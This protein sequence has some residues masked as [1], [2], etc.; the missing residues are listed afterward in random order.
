[1]LS[2]E[3][4]E[5]LSNGGEIQIRSILVQGLLTMDHSLIPPNLEK[6]K[7]GIS[8]FQ[9]I[10]KE[11][12]IN[13]VHLAI[14][15]INYLLPRARIIIGIDNTKQIKD[16]LSINKSKLRDSDIKAILKVCRSYSGDH[17]D[18]RKW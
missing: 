2:E 17:W 9:N 16:L 6:T 5:F 14:L 11:L 3:I 10:A 18:P 7:K 13:K 15:C 4:K 12:N 1:M 8:Y